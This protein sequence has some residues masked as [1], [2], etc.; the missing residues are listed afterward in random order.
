MT[1]NRSVIEQMFGVQPERTDRIIYLS[2][3]MDEQSVMNVTSQLF[4]FAGQDSFKPIHLIISTYGG[5]IDEM[6]GLYDA[7][8]LMPCPIHTIGLGKIM[9][10]GL[11]I[12]ASGTQGERMIGSN[13]RVMIHSARGCVSGNVFEII[14][15]TDE[16]LRHQSLLSD[17]VVQN[18]SM[19]REKV[20]ELMKC[21][22]DV[23]ISPEEAVTYGIVDKIAKSKT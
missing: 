3:V 15:E 4:T 17:L 18:T 20:D 14:N 8:K 6:F 22:H 7:I 11:L 13:A 12:L 19:T 16:M 1:S 9:S 21:G 23:Y 2:G 10:A 5:F